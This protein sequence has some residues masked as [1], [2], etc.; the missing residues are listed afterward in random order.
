MPYYG[1]DKSSDVN[2][3]IPQLLFMSLEYYI[4]SLLMFVHFQKGNEQ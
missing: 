3:R 4:N 2:D 1:V